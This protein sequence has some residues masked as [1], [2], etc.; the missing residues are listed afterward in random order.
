MQTTRSDCVFGPF[1]SRRL[2]RA[3]GVDLVPFKV[4]N[5]DCIYCRLGRTTK[6]TILRDTY[7]DFDSVVEEIDARLAFEPDY[8]ALTGSGEPVIHAQ[9]N[10]LMQRIRAVTGIP[11]AVLTNGG[12]FWRADVRA[13]MLDADLVIPSLDAGDNATLQ[14]MNRPHLRIGVDGIIDGLLRFKRAFSGPLWLEVTLVAGV[15]DSPR[16]L[17]RIR[18]ATRKICPD[19]VHL[20]TV[21]RPTVDEDAPALSRE[22]LEQI[23]DYFGPTAEVIA[24]WPV[25]DKTRRFPAGEDDIMAILEHRPCCTEE[26]AYGLGIRRGEVEECLDRL[27]RMGLVEDIGAGN[28]SVY[29][30]RRKLE[31]AG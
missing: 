9:L 29:R 12:L 28:T 22:R 30:C 21:T 14:A 27:V 18:R 19:K 20:S 25:V 17:E 26:I 7:R 5:F 2:G 24:D 6:K 3:L 10:Q 15:N 8:I 23:A 11:I 31:Q 16:S 4:C 1:L 13:E